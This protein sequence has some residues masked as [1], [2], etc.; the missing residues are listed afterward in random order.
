MK[1]TKLANWFSDENPA[2]NKSKT[3]PPTQTEVELSK[4]QSKIDKL[5]N[6]LQIS[7]KEL[8]QANAQLQI[9][10]GFRIELGE[11]Q[12]RLQ[13]TGE[14]MQRLKQ[15]LFEQQKQ[16]NA[17]QSQLQEAQQSLAQLTSAQNWLNQIKTPIEIVEIRKTLPKQE[18]EIL[19]G[20]GII[21]PDKKLIITT[22]AI[23]VRGWV[24]GKK[25]QAKTLIV[26]YQNKS[27]LETPVNQR[28]P[29]VIQQYPDIP[30]ANNCGFEFSLGL[31]GITGELELDLE[32]L[33]SDETVVPL[34]NFVLRPQII[35]ST[36][37]K[38]S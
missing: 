36:D 13:Q 27:L 11:T 4:M 7:Q 24:L 16:F 35:E 31:A 9:N 25:A 1:L 28:R 6:D 19:W 33:L 17:A 3:Q 38:S 18:F 20:F 5:S 14:Q 15:E 32:A 21:A 29:V 22:G 12:L 8:A 26:K 30:S 2:Q 23:A 10:Q 37:T 34:C